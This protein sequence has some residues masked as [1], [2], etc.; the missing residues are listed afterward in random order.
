MTGKPLM[1]MHEMTEEDVK[2]LFV[3]PAIHKAGWDPHAQMRLEYFFTDGRVI[4]NGHRAERGERKKADYLLYYKRNIPLAIVEAKDANHS[5]GAGMQ[6]ALDYAEIL[7]VPFAYSTN[8]K[9]FLEHDMKRGIE[10]ELKMDELPSPEELWQRYTS[11]EGYTPEQVQAVT[12][13]YY[14]KQGEKTPR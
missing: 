5:V 3:T 2:H 9:G 11:G 12:E 6:Q 4:V 8:G 1:R 13:P 7:D 14:F 10:R